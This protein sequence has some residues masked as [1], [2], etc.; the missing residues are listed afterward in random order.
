MSLETDCQKVKFSLYIHSYFNVLI[1]REIIKWDETAWNDTEFGEP[2][3]CGSRK[4]AEHI[5]ANGEQT[6][7]DGIKAFLTSQC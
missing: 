2:W 5:A 7:Q 6:Y 4:R 3:M 1:L